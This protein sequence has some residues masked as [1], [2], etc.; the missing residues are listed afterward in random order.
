MAQSKRLEADRPSE[1]QTPGLTEKG[2]LQVETGIRK[3]QLNKKDYSLYHPDLLLKWGLSQRFELRSEIKS[4]T[5]RYKSMN[6][7]EYGLQPV[8]LGFKAKLLEEKGALPQTTLLAQVGIPAWAS[9]DHKAPHAL[10]KVRLLFQNSLTNNIQ[11]GYNLGTEWEGNDTNPQWV[12]TFS[13]QFDIGDKWQL[14]IESY[15]FL[16]KGQAPQHVLDGGVA[17]YISSNLMWDIY[18]GAG[19]N[20]HA[21]DYFISSGISFRI[22]P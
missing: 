1:T 13:P 20:H 11:L 16:Q 6:E 15:G 2:F 17:Y 4:E 14:F 19:L 22:K 7:Y 8:E 12:Y 18:G 5:R 9:K 3:E 21:P 10:P